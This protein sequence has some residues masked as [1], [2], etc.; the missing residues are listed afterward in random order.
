VVR[1]ADLVARLGG[2][3]FAVLM[4]D[5]EREAAAIALAERLQSAVRKPILIGATEIATSASI[6]ITF[7]QFGYSTTEE[8]LRDADTAMYK[9]KSL[10][11]ARHAVFDAGLHATVSD[12]LALENDLR[13]AVDNRQ[14]A[15]VYQP[16][17]RLDDHG[18]I[19]FE[20]LL[21]WHHPVRGHVSPAV[22]VPIA[23]EAGL[24]GPITD[25]VLD[26]ACAQLRAAQLRHPA[27][28]GLRMHVNIS[29]Q[30]LQQRTLA[31]RVAQAL[32]TSGLQPHDLTLEIT[33][34]MLMERIDLALE[35]LDRL[36]QLGVGLSVDDF[37]TGYSSLAYLSS[38][39]I[40]SLK[41][42]A[43]FVRRL[44]ADG[45]DSE[46]V[47]AVIQLGGALGK[48]VIAEGI[49]THGQSQR[50]RELG[51]SMGQGY[52]LSRPLAPEQLGAL[53]DW[54]VAETRV[55]PAARPQEPAP[56]YLH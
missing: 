48:S 40:S 43:S 44:Q 21:R 6:G 24:I 51:C 49:E 14:L 50:L 22:F 23:E 52:H 35:T 27:L 13:R 55:P 56:A 8:V 2:D 37:G 28:R 17:F 29:G 4:V 25:W 39:P 26:Q 42:D 38:M 31:A 53:L 32:E 30:D 1:P 36:H 11:R 15:V 34:G 16:L 54:Q 45:K 47:R 7:S 19:G 9:A 20:A 41:I 33:E 10:G 3:E 18:L 46:I 12:R 5:M